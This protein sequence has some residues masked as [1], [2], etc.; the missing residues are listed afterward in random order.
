MRSILRRY[1]KRFVFGNTG[2][3]KLR[4]F[5]NWIYYPHNSSVF[6][7]ACD[8]GIFEW[9]LVRLICGLVEAKSWYFDVGAN[10]GLMS[11]PVLDRFSDVQVV[12]FEPSPTTVPYLQRTIAASAFKNRWNHC[13]LAV[14]SSV[15]V[16]RFT[17]TADGAFDGMRDT[18]RVAKQKS[19]ELECTTLDA[20]WSALG[21]PRVSVIKIDVEGGEFAV[22]DGARACVRGSRPCILL[23]WNAC[24]LAA[25]RVEAK[26]LLTYANEMNY[27]LFSAPALVPINSENALRMQMLRTENFLL[28]PR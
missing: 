24:N 21:K 3:R 19:V 8:E 14:C 5:G 28:C 11:I 7:R 15:G 18:D 6:L 27:D 23:E 20:R 10:I 4:Y 9:E 1:L 22:L 12:S 26:A 16:T 25:Y 2:L 17:M 13:E